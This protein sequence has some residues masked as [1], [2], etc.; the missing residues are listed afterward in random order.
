MSAGDDLQ[1]Q[2]ASE[3]KNCP[4]KIKVMTGKGEEKNKP[5]DITARGTCSSSLFCQLSFQGLQKPGWEGA[6]LI[7]SDACNYR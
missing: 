2:A 7:K 3:N 4:E 5:G 1:H 6:L